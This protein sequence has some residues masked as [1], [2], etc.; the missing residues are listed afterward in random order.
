MDELV[1][2]LKLFSETI[3]GGPVVEIILK[4]NSTFA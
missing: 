2:L 1:I 3:V 4:G